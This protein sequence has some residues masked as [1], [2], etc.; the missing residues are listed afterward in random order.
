M[1][2]RYHSDAGVAPAT[3]LFATLM[4]AV[5]G[6]TKA[7]IQGFD[8]T[9]RVH[10]SC[11]SYASNDD[12]FHCDF[13]PSTTQ[14]KVCCSRT[15]SATLTRLYSFVQDAEQGAQPPSRS[16]ENDSSPSGEEWTVICDLHAKATKAASSSE[17]KEA[18]FQYVVEEA[19]SKLSPVLIMKL[20]RGDSGVSDNVNN[21]D[22]DD[23]NI[24]KH[25]QF[26]EISQSLEK[27]LNKKLDV[28]RDTLAELLNAGEIKKLDALIGKSARAQQLDVAFFQVLQMNM[29]DAALEMQKQQLSQGDAKDDKDG[30]ANRLQ[31]LQHIHTRC[32][33]EVEKNI[34]PGIALLSK[35]LRTSVDSIRR[36]QLEHYL[37]P[38]PT[39]ITSPD[40]KQIEL[41]NPQNERSLVDHQDFVKAMADAVKQIRTVEQAG[42]TSRVVA[43][44]MVESCRQVAKE[45]RIVIGE[46]FGKESEQLKTFEDALMPVFRPS[47]P[48]SPYIR[49]ENSAM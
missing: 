25:Q 26:R 32:Q 28:A 14:R 36:N 39:T 43:A 1:K 31:I 37:C 12:D 3:F 19:L 11:T 18:T 9:S 47:S 30:T 6:G 5:M 16:P 27:M 42:G 41:K 10:E 7:W 38:Q 22:N 33:E 35:L 49:G 48:E 45:A 46:R 2:I 20:R 40:G 34:N 17:D 44:D 15:A 23:S 24:N 4:A 29:Q 21:D 8:G 13:R